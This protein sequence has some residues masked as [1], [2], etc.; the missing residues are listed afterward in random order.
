MKYQEMKQV[1]NLLYDEWDLGKKSSQAKGKVCAW[2]YLFEIL[3][4]SEKLILE[5]TNNKVIG[6]CGYSKWN[7]KKHLLKK[8]FY[9]TLKNILIHSPFIKNKQAI[10]K[11]YKNYDYLPQELENHFDGEISILIVD[12]NYRGNNYGKTLLLKT[13]EIA[14]QDNM[15]NLQILT[16]ESCNFT[17]YEKLGCKKIYE[18]T[19]I[20]SEPNKC[21]NTSS[22]KGFIYEKLLN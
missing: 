13:F 18:K 9:K 3:E 8:K 5:K 17:F 6:I 21:G 10:Y 22:E 7:S 4:E 19:I 11:Y 20:N 2:I 14:K 16:D 15:K 12:K 1:V